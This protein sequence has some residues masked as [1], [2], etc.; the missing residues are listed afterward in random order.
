MRHLLDTTRIFLDVGCG[1][2]KSSGAVGLDKRDIPGVDIVHDLEVIPWPLADESCRRVLM[3]HI[4]EHLKPWL[5]VDILDE[6]WRIMEPDGQLMIATPYAGSPRFWQDPTHI[7][8][9]MEATPE[10]FDP[11]YPLYDIYRP[12]PWKIE[13]NIWH[14]HG[15]MEVIFSKR[16]L[17]EPI[18]DLPI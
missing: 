18:K 9:W 6:V 4:I 14:S 2:N 7:H 3:S 10:Y 8:G 5:I 11:G 12:K 16:K 13:E 1:S 15:D 17:Y